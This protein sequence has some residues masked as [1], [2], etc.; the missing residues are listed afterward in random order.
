MCKDFFH[1][2]KID[3]TDEQPCEQPCEQPSKKLWNL[4]KYWYFRD[5]TRLNNPVNKAEQ[6]CE[7]PSKNLGNPHKCLISETEQGEQPEQPYSILEI[8][9][10]IF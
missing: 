8:L 10:E 5:W 9:I 4:H 3:I 7:Q 2:R 1:I 6:P